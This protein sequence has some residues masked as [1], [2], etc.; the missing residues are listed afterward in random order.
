MKKLIFLISFL[1]TLLPAGAVKKFEANPINVAVVIVEKGDSSKIIR[2]FDYYG[3]N[4]QGSADG[5]KIM[6]HSNGNEIRYSFTDSNDGSKNTQV[7]VKTKATHK[8]IE[9]LLS[10]LNF[11]KD[12]NIYERMIHRYNKQVTQCSLGPSNTLIFQRIKNQ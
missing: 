11:K 5:Y 10:E 1:F 12:G 9:K 2:I 6:K 8:E 4:Q 7:I 3:Y